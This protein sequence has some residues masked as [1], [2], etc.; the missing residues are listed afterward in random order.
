MAVIYAS[1][2]IRQGRSSRGPVGAGAMAMTGRGDHTFP[3]AAFTGNEDRR[4]HVGDL[5]NELADPFHSAAVAEQTFDVNRGGQGLA[6][7]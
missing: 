7:G 2:P 1:G 3:G 6:R 5:A 4:G